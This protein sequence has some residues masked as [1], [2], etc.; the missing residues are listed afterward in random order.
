[1]DKIQ[2][3]DAHEAAAVGLAGRITVGIGVVG[4]AAV[5]L[6]TALGGMAWLADNIPLL[7]TGV[8]ALVTGGFTSWV[9]VRR[10]KMDRGA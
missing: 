6:A 5:T 9:A 1:M 10:M 4:T 2:A 7:V 8:T 3:R